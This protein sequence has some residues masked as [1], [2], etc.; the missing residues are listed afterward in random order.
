MTKESVHKKEKQSVIRST[1]AMAAGTFSSRI[2]GFLRDAIMYALFPRSVTDAWV[3]AFRFWL[4][5]S[6]GK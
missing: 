3:V 2:L 4:S 6:I 1:I 5:A